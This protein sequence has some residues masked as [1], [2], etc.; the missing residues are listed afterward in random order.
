MKRIIM[1][2][3]I[4]VLTLATPV[5]RLDVA[6]LEPVEVVCLSRVGDTVI[7]STDTQASGRGA[8]ALSALANLKQTTPGVVYLDT[9]EFLLVTENALDEIDLL[10][11]ELKGSVKLCQVQN[12]ELENAAKY[13]EVHGD[14]PKLKAWKIGQK[15]P[16]W[17]GEKFL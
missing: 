5:K 10:R 1:Y 7:L 12:A 6:H 16:V 2:V 8:D 9:A 15:L 17:N 14:L 3:A 11:T 4:L 13:L